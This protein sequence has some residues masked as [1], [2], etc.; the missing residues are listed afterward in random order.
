MATCTCSLAR[1]VDAC[2]RV[3]WIPGTKPLYGGDCTRWYPK[4]AALALESN[5]TDISVETVPLNVYEMV[6][7]SLPPFKNDKPCNTVS[8]EDY[9]IETL[10]ISAAMTSSPRQR[11]SFVYCLFK[12]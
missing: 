5:N 4:I 9:S 3:S 6:P 12:Y 10:L 7:T 11:N 2:V 1:Q 8:D